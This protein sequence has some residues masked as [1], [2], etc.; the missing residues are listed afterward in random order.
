MSRSP[1]AAAYFTMSEETLRQK[2]SVPE[3]VRPLSA[4]PAENLDL[5]RWG[6]LDG[7]DRVR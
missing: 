5:E 7:A 4:L 2:P 1:L 6:R 3:A